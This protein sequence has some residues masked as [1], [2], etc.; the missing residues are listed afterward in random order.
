MNFLHFENLKDYA[1]LKTKEG[2]AQE[3]AAGSCIYILNM[4]S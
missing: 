1:K 4:R 2:D 3:L